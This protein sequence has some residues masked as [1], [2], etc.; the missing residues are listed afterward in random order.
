MSERYRVGLVLSSCVQMPSLSI[1]QD[2]EDEVGLPTLSA[3]TATTHAILRALGLETVVP[4][5]G[6]LL[7]AP[8]EAG[9]SRRRSGLAP[10][11][12]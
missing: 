10:L 4:R 8:S 9:R 1:L 3:A 6:R 7:A 2:I 5:A 11:V 12:D